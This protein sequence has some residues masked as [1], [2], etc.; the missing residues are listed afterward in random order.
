MPHG[1]RHATRIYVRAAADDRSVHL[2]VSDDGKTRPN[3]L[4]R[5]AGIRPGEVL[6]GVVD[7]VVCAN[8]PDQVH[9]SRAADAGHLR[10][11]R[12]GDHRPVRHRDRTVSP[13]DA[14]LR[15]G[16]GTR[17]LRQSAV[18]AITKLKPNTSTGLT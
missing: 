10:P 18:L 3:A 4:D 6:P 1:T 17:Q 14:E 5:V 16:G 7:D 11:E 12:L 15:E 8:G 2:R 9:V 13:T